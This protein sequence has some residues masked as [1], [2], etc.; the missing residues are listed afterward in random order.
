MVAAFISVLRYEYESIAT[1]LFSILII[2]TYEGITNSTIAFSAVCSVM[3]FRKDNE[4]LIP[5]DI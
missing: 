5:K 1:K 4:S 3:N 2:G